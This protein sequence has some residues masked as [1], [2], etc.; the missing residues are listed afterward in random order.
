[1]AQV[2]SGPGYPWLAAWQR[3][4]GN[5]SGPGGQGGMTDSAVRAPAGGGGGECPRT[6]ARRRDARP[7]C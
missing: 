2:C 7:R 1:M 5:A 6:G 3:A 4:A